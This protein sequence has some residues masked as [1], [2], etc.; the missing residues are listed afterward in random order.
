MQGTGMTRSGDLRV[1]K[2]LRRA[3]VRATRAPSVHNTQPWRF[4]LRADSLEIHADRTRQLRVLDPRGRQLIISCGCALFNTRVALAAAGIAA[5]VERIPDQ[6]RPAVVA[7][8]MASGVRLADDALI[9]HLDPSIDTRQTNRRRFSDAVVPESLVTLLRESAAAEACDLF[10]VVRDEHRLALA[11]LSQVADRIENADPAYRAELRQWTSDDPGRDDGV[12][13]YA[14]P[15]VDG[16]A[17][18]AVPMRDFDTHGMGWLP[19]RTESSARQCLLLIGTDDDNPAAWVR[20]GEAL[21]HVLLEITRA[22]YAASP[23]TQVIEVPQTHAALR[24]DLGLAMHPHILLRVGRAPITPATRR[25]RL[26]D[27]I[28]EG[29]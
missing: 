6:L 11:E 12:P 5:D 10:P 25:R 19:S 22:G 2:A 3:A 1:A 13:S 18:D 20:T 23:L 26:A 28:V 14:V 27:V 24:E 9:A 15:H 29:Q 4:V 7:K 16:R 8:V 21:E 17:G